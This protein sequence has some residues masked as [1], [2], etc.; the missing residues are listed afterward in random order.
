EQDERRVRLH[1][2]APGGP[3]VYE[4]DRAVLAVPFPPLRRVAFD[5]PLS[6][7]KQRA[8]REL[9][10]AALSRVALQ[11]R[12]RPWTK[13]GRPLFAKT[14]LPSE[15]WDATWDHPGERGIVSV[16]VKSQ[17]ALELA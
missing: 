17:A 2:S 14:D 1:G 10:Y 15:I 9:R 13:S 4:A 6:A 16:F 12:S 3:E 11:V 7:G 8:I 5:P